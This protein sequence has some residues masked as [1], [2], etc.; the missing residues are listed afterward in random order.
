MLRRFN[1]VQ[2]KRVGVAVGGK[3]LHLGVLWPYPKIFYQND[4]RVSLFNQKEYKF[5][6]NDILGKNFRFYPVLGTL[7]KGPLSSSELR[8]ISTK[9]I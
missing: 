9:K 4:K 5:Y 3:V 7:S 2:P 6:M 1:L 8:T